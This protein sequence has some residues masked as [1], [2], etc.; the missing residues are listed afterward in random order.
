METILKTREFGTRRF[1]SLILA[2][3][4]IVLVIPFGAVGEMAGGVDVSVGNPPSSNVTSNNVVAPRTG[5]IHPIEDETDLVAFLQGT[6]GGNAD[7]FVLTRDMVLTAGMG[8]F[9]GRGIIGGEVF[10]GLFDGAGHTITGLQ[11]ANAAGAGYSFGFIRE[12][13]FGAEIRNVT[14]TNATYTNVPLAGWNTAVGGVGI[15]LGRAVGGAV[16]ISNVTTTSTITFGAGAAQTNKRVGGL[17]GIVAA[18]ATLNVSGV[19]VTANQITIAAGMGGNFAGGILGENSGVFNLTAP[20]GQVNLVDVYIARAGTGW[21]IDAGGVL[22]RSSA[23]NVTIRDTIV[24]GVVTTRQTGGGLIGHTVAVAG[25]TRVYDSANYATIVALNPGTGTANRLAVNEVGGIIGFANNQTF[26]TSVENT[27]HILA[28]RTGGR[29]ADEGVRQGGIVG[30][31]MNRIE[32]RDSANYGTIQRTGAASNGGNRIGGIIGRAQHPAAVANQ[33]IYLNGVTNFGLISDGGAAP[34]AGGIIGH[35]SGGGNTTSRM[36]IRNARNHGTVRAAGGGE[37]GGGGGILGWNQTRNALIEYTVNHA[38]VDHIGTSGMGGVG[39]I[40]GQNRAEDLTIRNTGNEGRVHHPGNGSRGIGGIIGQNRG[41]RLLI[42]ATYNSGQISNGGAGGNGW[43]LGGFIG[44]QRSGTV[45]IDGF[46]NI[47][48]ITSNTAN[49]GSGVVGRRTGGSVTI[50]NG[51]VA[52]HSHGVQVYRSHNDAN[53]RSGGVRVANASFSNVY[54]VNTVGAPSGT[55]N[56]NRL[57]TNRTGIVLIDADI[58]TLGILPGVSGGPWRVGIDGQEDYQSTLPYFAWQVQGMTSSGLSPQFFNEITPNALNSPATPATGSTTLAVSGVFNQWQTRQFA[59]NFAPGWSAT[60]NN[61]RPTATGINFNVTAP[62][63]NSRLTWG[64][65]SLRGVVGFG[66][67]PEDTFIITLVDEVDGEVIGHA[68]ISQPSGLSAANTIHNDGGILLARTANIT[69]GMT[70]N[71]S[72]LGYVPQTG[73]QITDEHFA[74]GRM[75]VP[76]ER[77]LIDRPINIIVRNGSFELPEDS[78]A[79]QPNITDASSLAHLGTPNTTRGGSGNL[80]HFFFPANTV[81]IGDLM[82]IG[83]PGFDWLDYLFSLRD[84]YDINAATIRVDVELEDNRITH[85]VPV[86]IYGEVFNPVTEEY[87]LEML[88]GVT[89]TATNPPIVNEH[90]ALGVTGT[91]PFILANGTLHTILTV[92]APGFIG[93]DFV[94]GDYYNEFVPAEDGEDAIPAHIAIV[95]ERMPEFTVNV[96]EQFTTATGATAYRLI[97]NAILQI[98]TNPIAGSGGAFTVATPLGTEVT[99]SAI[100]FANG[101]HTFVESDLDEVVQIVLTRVAPPAG[102]IN[103][104]VRESDRVT[105]IAGAAVGLLNASNQVVATT[106]AD[107]NGFFV[108]AGL[109]AGTYRVIASA[110]GFNTGVSVVDPIVL[111]AAAGV[112]ADV[113]LEAEDAANP[114]QYLLL[115]DV[116]RENGTRI[117]DATVTFN[118]DTIT[119]GTTTWNRYLTAPTAGAVRAT[120]AN[121]RTAERNV[122]VS[123]FHAMLRFHAVTLTMEGFTLQPGQGGIFGVVTRQADGA[124][125]AGATVIAVNA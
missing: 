44:R 17:V 47:G 57:Q 54:I 14:F 22:G 34:V 112:R 52:A 60:G 77:T 6:L 80:R 15:I 62:H 21:W 99:A 65:I 45:V 86:R 46:Y 82:E 7:T 124:P 70:F 103:G 13:G 24:T 1:I 51:F 36:T 58:L 30:R 38:R 88:S 93:G 95:L 5:I 89:L 55:T 16:A 75:V 10:T 83:A 32:I 42:Q 92:N 56:I 94:A 111:T 100:G 78:D 20:N 29:A 39:G 114:N 71:A 109:T 4:M 113:Y 28:S 125:I 18:G 107:A 121:Y 76:M 31:S 72:A 50:R 66:A 9:Q 68:T 33:V 105:I 74:A 23:G 91:N 40:V 122:Q 27:G 108:F 87:E 97:P 3:M 59:P 43:R 104:F 37:S 110:T 115:V 73:L 48:P 64:L 53:N 106:T 102:T 116:V 12:A 117:N 67:I 118:G 84:A 8:V 11:L 101:T 2:I 26:L 61:S 63:V 123:D 25:I 81:T 35:T 85:N 90:A 120:M 41:T 69:P 96:V 19:D 119:R 98:G 49:R 79:D